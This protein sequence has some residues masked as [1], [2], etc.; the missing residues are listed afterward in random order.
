MPVIKKC[1]ICSKEFS[2][3]PARAN[4]AKYCGRA[5]KDKSV[6]LT[7]GENHPRWQ[8]GIRSKICGHCKIE[9]AWSGQPLGIWKK[10]KFCCKPCADQGGLR[11]EGEAHSNWKPDSRKK[12]RRGKHG[13]WADK[14]ISRDNATCQKC[15]SHE[16][17]QAHHILS[18]AEHPE[19]RW[20]I[21]NGLTV[22]F[23]CHLII[24]GAQIANEVNSGEVRPDYERSEDYP[25]PSIERKLIEG[26]TTRG[27]A[28]RRWFGHCEWCSV[29]IS[30]PWSDVQGKAHSFCS[31]T[32][33]GKYNAAHRTYRQWKNPE[34]PTAVISS[35]S[36]PPERDDIV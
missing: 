16:N 19:A 26:V 2:V 3:I 33:S 32:C 23:S 1:E 34:S 13:S 12:N 4:T 29:F 27:R 6:S 18:F 30:K 24:H 10:Q 5:C 35:K 31:R 28:Y 15:G 14:V 20:D 25:E 36:A 22:C 7:T 11:Y 9:F 17:L 21:A 8:G